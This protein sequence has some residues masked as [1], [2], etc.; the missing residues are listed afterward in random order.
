MSF[1]EESDLWQVDVRVEIVNKPERG[2]DDIRGS[3]KG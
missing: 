3:E 2:Q 1:N